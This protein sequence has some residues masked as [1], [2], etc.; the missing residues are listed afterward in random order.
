MYCSL[1]SSAGKLDASASVVA[2][3]LDLTDCNASFD[4]ARLRSLTLS[5]KPW[6][7]HVL[8]ELGRKTLRSL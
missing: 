1:Q 4:G 5:S 7:S 6:A 8:L 3:T 2:G